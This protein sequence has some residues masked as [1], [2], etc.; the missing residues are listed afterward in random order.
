VE[1]EARREG[2]AGRRFFGFGRGTLSIAGTPVGEG[3]NAVRPLRQ[4]GAWGPVSGAVIFSMRKRRTK[5][6]FRCRME[7]P[8]ASSESGCQ[9]LSVN[10]SRFPLILRLPY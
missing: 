5:K 2:G 10:E 4:T 9:Y 1:G 6:R 8:W 7:I 3:R